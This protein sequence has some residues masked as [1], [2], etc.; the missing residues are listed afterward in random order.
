MYLTVYSR[1]PVALGQSPIQNLTVKALPAH[2]LWCQQ[3]YTP[4]LVTSPY[5][6]SYLFR[7]HGTYS[8]PASWTVWLP[9]FAEQEAQVVID[10][11]NS[12]DG[13]AP[14]HLAAALVNGHSRWHATD[15]FRLGSV[16]NGQIL[17]RKGREAIEIAA[18]TLGKKDVKS[19]GRFA[20]S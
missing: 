20:G 15:F 10:L 6:P 2:H 14:S 9:H 16:E 13:G 18:L 4:T 11:G 5:V 7:A 3:N 1:L 17:A 8:L 19:Q 12:G